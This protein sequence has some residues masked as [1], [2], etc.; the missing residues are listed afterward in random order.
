[1]R[2]VW[3]FWSKPFKAFK[4]R[5]WREPRHHLY[6]WGLSLR[7]AREHYPE[8]VLV[9]DTPGKALLVDALGL[10]FAQ[11]STEL[12]RLHDADHGWWALGKLVAYGL[13]DRPFV[14]LDTDVFLWQAL[15]AALTAAPVFAQCPE[16]HA[17]QHAWCRPP[18]IVRLFERHGL[19]VPVEWEWDSSRIATWFREESCGIVGGNRVDFIRHY[20]N[21]AIGMVLDPAHAAA[22]TELPD[23]GAYNMLIEQY[24]L[25]ACVAYHRYHPESRFRGVTVRHLFPTWEEAFNQRAAA[26]AGY[27][28]LLGDAK[29]HP[30]VADRLE[31]RIAA[32]D[33]VFHR[34]CQRI[35]LAVF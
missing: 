20:A 31:R 26:R 35:A 4:G 3:S 13:Q 29:T 6:A 17:M 30:E 15:P 25:A 5:I 33:P 11:V 32:L 34:H 27:T 16:G 2:A 22:W 8:T 18:D 7:M 12:D 9:T 24:F 14:H 1:M 23:K 10:E 21:A 19:T 28:H